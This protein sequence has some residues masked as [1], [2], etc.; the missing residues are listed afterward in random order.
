MNTVY[1]RPP[2]E[3]YVIGVYRTMVKNFISRSGAI[4]LQHETNTEN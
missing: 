2:K 4:F 3:N 1:S